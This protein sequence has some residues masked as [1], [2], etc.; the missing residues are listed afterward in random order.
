MRW[1]KLKDPSGRVVSN[2]LLVPY[3]FLLIRNFWLWDWLS[4]CDGLMY[5]RI[6][7]TSKLLH[8]Q[9]SLH[10]T[11]LVDGLEQSWKKDKFWNVALEFGE[12]TLFSPERQ[13]C[14]TGGPQAAL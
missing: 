12:K 11:D 1:D 13:A 5:V 9:I 8:G 4:F 14:Q 3:I 10:S 2:Q 6:S 7:I